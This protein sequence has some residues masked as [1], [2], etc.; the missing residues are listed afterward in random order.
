MVRGW[1]WGLDIVQRSSCVI[2]PQRLGVLRGDR[3][4][5]EDCEEERK[6]YGKRS[7]ECLSSWRP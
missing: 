7:D 5:K 3:K 6:G 4:S 1:E 2:Q